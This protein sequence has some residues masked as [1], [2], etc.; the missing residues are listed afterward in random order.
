MTIRHETTPGRAPA[1]APPMEVPQAPR[2]QTRPPNRGQ[3]A[4][5]VVNRWTTA[6]LLRAGLG[7]WMGTPVGGYL[8]LLRVRGRRTGRI[9]E[10]P[11][12]YCV[13]EGSAWVAAS[14]G[15]GAQ[16]YRNLVADPGVEVV[17]PGRT[18]ACSAADVTDE[19]VRRRVIPIY[20]RALGLPGRMGGLDPREP[21]EALLAVFGSLPLI[22]LDPVAGSLVAGP[23]DPGG[24]AWIW[25]QA[26]VLALAISVGRMARSAAR[27]ARAGRRP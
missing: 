19:E 6:P 9:H 26:V 12:S 25:R 10:V 4:F 17:L 24:R 23:D 11:L 3:A 16:W 7:T 18:L 22:R 20:A 15:T 8:L 14:M 27:R 13:A 2:A 1:P 5:R 21:D